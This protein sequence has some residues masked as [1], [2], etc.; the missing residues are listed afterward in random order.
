[1]RDGTCATGGAAAGVVLALQASVCRKTGCVGA[2]PWPSSAQQGFVCTFPPLAFIPPCPGLFCG[3][4][5][6]L[7]EAFQC[8]A[9]CWILFLYKPSRL[10]DSFASQGWGNSQYFQSLDHIGG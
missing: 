10:G 3:V 1:M 7:D 4:V 2:G 5:Q 9:K 8:V 6:Y